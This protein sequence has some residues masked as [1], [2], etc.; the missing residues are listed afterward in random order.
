MTQGIVE[1]TAL[2]WSSPAAYRRLRSCVQVVFGLEALLCVLAVARITILSGAHGTDF[3]TFYD[4]GRAVLHGL[5]PY[6]ALRSLPPVAD[7]TSFAPFVYPPPVAF[8]MIPISLLPAAVA[9]VVFFC[10]SIAAT[11]LGL[12]VLGVRDRLCY[13]VAFS[14]VPVLAAPGNGSIS[15]FLFLGTALA[16]RYRARTWPLAI[17][18]GSIVVAK[19]FL[20]PLWLWLVATRRYRAA[21]LSAAFGAGL[22]IV[23]WAILGFAGLR[24]YATLLRR[25][26]ELTGVNS[27][28]LYALERAFGVPP[29]VAQ[30]GLFAVGGVVAWLAVR[31]ATGEQRD[32]RL[33]M[34]A[35]GLALLLT[36]ILWSHYLILL[37]VPIAIARPTLSR[38]WLLTFLFWLDPSSW[39][40]GDPVRIAPL[41]AFS[42]YLV[43]GS[44]RAVR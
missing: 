10:L 43:V 4:S 39:S 37:F 26:S 16:W 25:L 13:A 7:R 29:S 19:V 32:E 12:R 28:S 24:D 36:P 35:I 23:T 5:S 6:P 21:A 30:L 9:N 44:M 17:A 38:L 2:T 20:W 18:V 11:V 8:A 3:R 41:L 27:Y 1:G 15:A 22:T 40:F 42:A 31:Y 34:A 14:T 33:F